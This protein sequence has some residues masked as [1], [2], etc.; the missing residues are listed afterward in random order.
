MFIIWVVGRAEGIL[1]YEE[2]TVFNFYISRET[3]VSHSKC[4]S[5]HVCEKA[6]FL[7]SSF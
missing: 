1:N 3:Y 7:F 5:N 4:Y 2:G 6:G